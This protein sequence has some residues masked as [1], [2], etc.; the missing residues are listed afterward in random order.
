MVAYYSVF[1]PWFYK[2]IYATVRNAFADNLKI[3][4]FDNNY[5]FNACIMAGKSVEGFVAEPSAEAKLEAASLQRMTGRIFIWS[6]RPSPH[7]TSRCLAW[8]PS[9]C[10]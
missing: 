1:K 6:G 9:A 4:L 10:S 3:F 2:R 8:W 5:L 7:F